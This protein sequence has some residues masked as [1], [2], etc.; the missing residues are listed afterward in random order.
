[1]KLNRSFLLLTW[2]FQ[3]PLEPETTKYV[4]TINILGAYSTPDIVL[5][6]PY[7][8]NCSDCMR[9]EPMT[10]SFCR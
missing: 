1:M 3:C 8:L 10:P 9:W 2:V 4:I 6:L 5:S 7:T